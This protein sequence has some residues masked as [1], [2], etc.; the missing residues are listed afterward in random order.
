RKDGGS[1][2]SWCA[3]WPRRMGAKSPYR[4]LRIVGRSSVLSFPRTRVS[5][6]SRVR[7]PENPDSPVEIRPKRQRVAVHQSVHRLEPLDEGFSELDLAREQVELALLKQ[8][9]GLD[10][11][12]ELD[13]PLA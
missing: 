1:D 2:W 5:T 12:L 13:A 10:Q 8:A 6:A 7:R 4:V 9:T 3:E 11:V